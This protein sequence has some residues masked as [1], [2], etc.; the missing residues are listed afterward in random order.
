[1]TWRTTR[2]LLIVVLSVLFCLA[3]ASCGGGAG[4]GTGD[5]T[6]ADAGEGASVGVSEGAVA[7]AAD[8][9]GD[10]VAT[11]TTDAAND[12]ASPPG[13]GD[14]ASAAGV[15]SDA[16]TQEQEQ[17]PQ[18]QTQADGKSSADTSGKSGNSE[19]TDGK[20]PATDSAG[21]S[22][23]SGGKGTPDASPPKG[24]DTKP[25]SKPADTQSEQITV[26]VSADCKTLLAKNPD[27]AAKLSEDGVILA[28]KSVTL[29]AGSNVLDAL[30][31]SGI[32]YVG[33][34]Y[35]ASIGGL[36]EMDMGAK[37]GWVYSVNGTYP[38]KGVA[39]YK[40]KDGDD[41]RFRYTL[42]GGADVKS[43]A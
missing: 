15:G 24:N 23:K 28:P 8:A 31:A 25:P 14:S 32:A 36:S 38:G 29:P 3:L 33:S 17:P 39:G 20:K 26:T 7:S 34:V 43:E 30:K 12:S 40:L 22:D 9:D 19:K 11:G 27:L 10:A 18:K 42:N 1:M 35:I 2:R 21:N 6:D 37:S 41:V 13:L 4:G 16:Q 5:G